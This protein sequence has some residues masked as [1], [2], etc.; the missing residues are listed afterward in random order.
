M[1]IK[2]ILTI[3]ISLIV[4]FVL[5]YLIAGQS[6]KRD[7]KKRHSHSYSEMFVQKTLHI[8]E[9]SDIQKDSLMPIISDYAEKTMVLKNKVSGEFDSLMHKMNLDLKPYLSEDQYQ[10][11]EETGKNLRQKYGR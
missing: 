5:G 4:G 10:K 9:P 8:I 6:I 7:V 11:L 2:A 1:K 3:L